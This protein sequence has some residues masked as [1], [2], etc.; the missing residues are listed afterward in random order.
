VTVPIRGLTPRRV[1]G[2][3]PANADASGAHIESPGRLNASAQARRPR[4]RRARR[5]AHGGGG[6]RTRVRGSADR[7]STSVVRTCISPAGRCTDDLPTGQPSCGVAPRAIGSPSA[8]SPFVDAA[9]PATGRAGSDAPHYWLG[10]ES[11]CAIV[12]RTCC[13]SRLFY[14]ADRGPRLAALPEIDHVETW[15]PPYVRRIVAA[16]SCESGNN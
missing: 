14:E 11:E 7:T 12:I 15:S 9:V 1:L 8:P 4:R 16:F 13:W 5:A 10:S 6:N 2:K 3:V